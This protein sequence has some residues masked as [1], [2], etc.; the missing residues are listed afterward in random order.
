MDQLRT[1]LN[2]LKKMINSPQT[3]LIDYLSNLR[4][5][6]NYLFVDKQEKKF[7]KVWTQMIKKIDQFERESLNRLSEFEECFSNQFKYET[8]LR[9]SI[10]EEEMINL[11][12]INWNN[13]FRIDDFREIL[14]KEKTKLERIIFSNQTIMLLDKDCPLKELISKVLNARLIIIRDVYIC[15]D[16]IYNV[17]LN[18][19]TMAMVGNITRQLMSI[20]VLKETICNYYNFIIDISLNMKSLDMVNLQNNV[21][22]VLEEDA[23]DDLYHIES[24]FITNSFLNFV[25]PKAFVAFDKLKSLDLS[26]NGVFYLDP[27]LFNDM[28]SLEFLNLSYNFMGYFDFNILKNLFNLKVL[29]LS[30]IG[31]ERIPEN[32]LSHLAL[33]EELHLGKNR[34]EDVEQSTFTGLSNLK[35]LNL[36]KN[37]LKDIKRNCFSELKCLEKLILF[38]N[39]ISSFDINALNGLDQLE[40]IIL[41]GNPIIDNLKYRAVLFEQ[42]KER[43]PDFIRKS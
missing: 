26:N 9:L 29:N 32:S 42:L 27:F 31:I 1:Q 34:L 37:K 30:G 16:S 13:S 7:Q 21:F 23:F 20:I 28:H 40:L 4:D 41:V 39:E 38:K 6:V 17:K 35:F 8:R 43:Y 15:K 22:S 12:P 24:L 3:Y 14:I 25:H 5:Q 19:D 33:L 11:G 36:G 10:I 18:L 2:E